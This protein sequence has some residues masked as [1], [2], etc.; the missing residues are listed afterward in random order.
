MI[1]CELN[2][3]AQTKENF[4]KAPFELRE[5]KSERHRHD[6][7]HSWNERILGVAPS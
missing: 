7:L 6:D 3:G 2:T 4:N 1:E 5:E